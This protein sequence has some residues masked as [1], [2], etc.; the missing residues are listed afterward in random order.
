MVEFVIALPLL[1]VLLFALVEIGIVFKDWLNVTDTA[2]VAARAA[3]VARFGSPPNNTPCAAAQQAVTNASN[4]SVLGACAPGT[5]QCPPN[6]SIKVTVTHPW[7]LNVPFIP[8]TPGGGD[9]TSDVTE[10]L[11]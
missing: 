2:R 1:V 11:E 5:L 10:C 9:L 3:A 4:G 6:G 7:S 8:I